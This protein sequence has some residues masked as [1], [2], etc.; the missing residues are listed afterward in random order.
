MWVESV[1]QNSV[2]SC[3]LE[4]KLSRWERGNHPGGGSFSETMKHFELQPHFGRNFDVYWIDNRKKTFATEADVLDFAFE[5]FVD[6]IR[7]ATQQ[8]KTQ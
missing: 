3:R 1:Y 5:Y 6:S 2:E 4:I 7:K 8:R